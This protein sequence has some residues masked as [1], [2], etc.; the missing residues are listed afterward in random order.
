MYSLNRLSIKSCISSLVGISTSDA[1][2]D[3]RLCQSWSGLL[4]YV[5]EV[6]IYLPVNRNVHGVNVLRR[7]LGFVGGSRKKI[8]KNRKNTKKL[9]KRKN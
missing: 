6:K 5:S 2:E 8:N 3:N 9:N 1:V 4:V 7:Q